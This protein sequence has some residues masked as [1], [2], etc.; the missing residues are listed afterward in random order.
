LVDQLSVLVID[1]GP[2]DGAV[3]AAKSAETQ[4]EWLPMGVA[5]D[6]GA[7]FPPDFYLPASIVKDQ[8]ALK[9]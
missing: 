3:T 6:G 5:S 9:P 4:A 1:G 8:L 7:P 2:G